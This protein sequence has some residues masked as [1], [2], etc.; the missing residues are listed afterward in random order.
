MYIIIISIFLFILT[1][2]SE[3]NINIS[4]TFIISNNLLYVDKTYKFY[5]ENIYM[6]A[7]IPT[8]VS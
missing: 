5:N 4:R 3:V 2:F 1:L 7:A 6:F 8:M